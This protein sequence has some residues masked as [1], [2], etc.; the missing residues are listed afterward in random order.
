MKEKEETED[1]K[2]QKRKEEQCY[3]RLHLMLSFHSDKNKTGW[4]HKKLP[5]LISEKARI[6]CW[7][8]EI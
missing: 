8:S 7:S 1:M 5:C 4:Q 6:C 2:Q 3:L